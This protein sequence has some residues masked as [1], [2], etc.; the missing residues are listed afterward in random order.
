MACFVFCRC[1]T[2]S[3]NSSV[4]DK[5][6]QGTVDTK[7]SGQ[8]WGQ[9][10]RWWAQLLGTKGRLTVGFFPYLLLPVWEGLVTLLLGHGFS[11]VH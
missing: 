9:L 6:I 7:A 10:R 1:F 4:G 3:Q 5:A 2:R 11:V 8:P